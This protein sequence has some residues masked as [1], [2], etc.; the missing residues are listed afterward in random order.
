M[1]E[2]NSSVELI[3]DALLFSTSTSAPTLTVYQ[4]I[5]EALAVLFADFI[6]FSPLTAQITVK[7]ITERV[8][9]LPTLVTSFI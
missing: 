1:P 6:N 8:V 5:L 9:A 3:F 7:H 4:L 2:S